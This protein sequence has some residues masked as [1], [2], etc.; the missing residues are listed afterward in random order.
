M[1]NELKRWIPVCFPMGPFKG[2][3]TIALKGKNVLSAKEA[4]E[5]IDMT[6]GQMKNG[7]LHKNTLDGIGSAGSEGKATFPEG[8]QICPDVHACED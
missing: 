6:E 4:K 7:V 2:N 3:V 5:L 8:R 1:T